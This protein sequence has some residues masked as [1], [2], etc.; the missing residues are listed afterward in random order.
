MAQCPLWHT[1]RSTFVGHSEVTWASLHLKPQLQAMASY[2]NRF[3]VDHIL[4]STVFAVDGRASWAVAAACKRR[5]AA[6]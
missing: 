1:C 3:E 6:N 2:L 5:Y 4:I